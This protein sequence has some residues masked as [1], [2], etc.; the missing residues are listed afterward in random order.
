MGLS[1]NS[2]ALPPRTLCQILTA[3]LPHPL[4]LETQ[5]ETDSV[6]SPWVWKHEGVII[7]PLHVYFFIFIFKNNNTIFNSLFFFSI[8][9]HGFP[10]PCLYVI[11]QGPGSAGPSPRGTRQIPEGNPAWW[12]SPPPS[13]PCCQ[14]K[15]SWV[16]QPAQAPNLSLIAQ[17]FYCFWPGCFE[18][19]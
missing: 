18:K 11:S 7:F 2:Y 19:G 5:N 15:P 8:F 1:P 14:R 17:H 4:T 16:P 13:F 12:L 6:V 9:H 3:P 10:S